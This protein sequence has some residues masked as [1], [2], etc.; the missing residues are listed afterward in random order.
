MSSFISN[1]LSSFSPL[2]RNRPIDADGDR[3]NSGGG[4]GDGGSGGEMAAAE[5]A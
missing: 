1:L 4:G 2:N 3:G 5:A